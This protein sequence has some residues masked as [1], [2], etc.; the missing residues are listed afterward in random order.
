MTCAAEHYYSSVIDP[1]GFRY[2]CINEVGN[3]KYAIAS[4]IDSKI[5][6]QAAIAKYLGRD[7][8]SEEECC[9]C[10][11][12]PLCYGRCVWE[13]KDKGVHSC[14]AARY[15]FENMIRQKFL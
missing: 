4:V 11:Y 13:Y 5:C 3:P 14:I 2:Q 15:I 7:P 6:S 10:V 1:Q 8:F 9:D 12:L